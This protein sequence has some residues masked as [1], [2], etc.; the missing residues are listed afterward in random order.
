LY[1]YVN[2]PSGKPMQPL[3]G[4]FMKMVLSKEGQEEVLK[5]GY[6]PLPAKVVE[7]DLKKVG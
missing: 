5:D 4:E 1:V 7:E 6:F 2:K 3:A